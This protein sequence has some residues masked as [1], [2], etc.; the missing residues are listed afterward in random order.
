MEKPTKLYEGFMG[1]LTGAWILIGA[2][3][4][5]GEWF[6]NGAHK[7]LLALICYGLCFL[8]MAVRALTHIAYSLRQLAERT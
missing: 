8:T 7:T 2:W 6:Y 3:F 4:Y 1:A 5:I